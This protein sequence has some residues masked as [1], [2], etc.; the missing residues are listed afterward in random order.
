M[1][2]IL[3]LTD[4]SISADYA[5]D[6]ALALAQQ[7]EA[8]LL[9]CNIFERPADENIPD[10]KAWPRQACEEDSINDLGALM[11]RLKTK[12]DN[13]VLGEKYKPEID[14]CSVDGTIDKKL[15]AIIAKHEVLLAVISAHSS[16]NLADVFQKDHAWNI[17]DQ[18]TFPVMV[19]PYQTRYRPFSHIAFA[20][21][22]NS[23]DIPVLKSVAAIAQYSN[24]EV[25]VTHINPKCQ[26]KN[27]L[28]NFFSQIPFKITYPRISYH[29]IQGSNIVRFLKQQC[30]YVDLLVLIHYK[31]SFLQNI[32]S[33][34]VTRKMAAHPRKPLLIFPQS[35]IN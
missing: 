13:D 22:M 2:T 1:K 24:S 12:L 30:V 21:G 15:T 16:R 19:I 10:R 18:A 5:A 8:N 31:R 35:V 3:V 20:T 7:I 23:T 27:S 32:F 26:A 25:L 14:Q 11:A 33:Q 28:Q 9:L 6:Y 29:S 4:F 34:R 17:I